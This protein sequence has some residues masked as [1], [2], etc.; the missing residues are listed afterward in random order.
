MK[1]GES[2]SE[3]SLDDILASIRKIIA[4]EPGQAAAP[5]AP[6]ALQPRGYRAE[7]N[8]RDRYIHTRGCN[9]TVRYIHTMGRCGC[10]G[11]RSPLCCLRCSVLGGE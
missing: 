11:L 1:R 9:I 8:R 3:E 2:G 6:D 4:D 10:I 5:P 7:H